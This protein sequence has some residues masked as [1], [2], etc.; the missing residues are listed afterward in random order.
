MQCLLVL[1][2]GLEC[3][4]RMLTEPRLRKPSSVVGFFSVWRSA[5]H[6]QKAI[7][8]QRYCSVQFAGLTWKSESKL[9][10]MLSR[11]P[12]PK[13]RATLFLPCL[14]VIPHTEIGTFH[15]R[16]QQDFLTPCA[17]AVHPPKQEGRESAFQVAGLNDHT[18]R[19]ESRYLKRKP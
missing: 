16:L 11:I 2:G 7:H 15:A 4:Y 5:A 3:T 13:S 19:G 12:E 18:L 9:C 17:M 14:C 10:V 1:V 6:A 8:V